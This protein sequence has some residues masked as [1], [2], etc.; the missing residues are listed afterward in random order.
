M[1]FAGRFQHFLSLLYCALQRQLQQLM[2]TSL[3]A[4]HTK[5]E[6]QVRR[7]KRTRSE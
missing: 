1:L 2:L 3:P 6:V 5:R 4:H 7:G